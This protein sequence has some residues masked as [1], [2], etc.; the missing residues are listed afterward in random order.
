MPVVYTMYARFETKMR[1]AR[2]RLAF[3]AAFALVPPIA[4]A[5]RKRSRCRIFTAFY[6]PDLILT[7]IF[8]YPARGTRSTPRRLFRPFS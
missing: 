1:K 2:G 4:A 3:T 5:L 8:F 7:A 6:A